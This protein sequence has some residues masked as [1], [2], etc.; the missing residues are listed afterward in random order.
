MDENSLEYIS[1]K[2]KHQWGGIKCFAVIQ[3]YNINKQL[4]QNEISPMIVFKD[5]GK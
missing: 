1:F 5:Y 3:Y 4:T 2:L